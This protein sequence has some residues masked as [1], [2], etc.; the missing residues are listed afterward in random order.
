MN[1]G[2]RLLVWY[3]VYATQVSP[4]VPHVEAEDAYGK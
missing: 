3:A 2:D 4:S 1:E